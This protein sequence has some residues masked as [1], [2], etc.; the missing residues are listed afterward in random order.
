MTENLPAE[1]PT[2]APTASPPPRDDYAATVIALSLSGAYREG[3][4]LTL[5]NPPT[6]DQRQALAVRQRVLLTH[7]GRHDRKAVA[8]AVFEMIS[9]YPQMMKLKADEARPIVA[10]YVQELS[11][12]PTWAC[13]YACN[14]I[15]M[16]NAPGVSLQYVPSTMQVLQAALDYAKTWRDEATAIGQIL[17]GS[18]YEKRVSDADREKVAIRLA[19][20]GESMRGKISAERDAERAARRARNPLPTDEDLRRLY[21]PTVDKVPDHAE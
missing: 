18:K 13:E 5:M 17:S 6:K 21:A 7:L 8:K 15:R 4:T 20:L 14:T 3:K 16:G 11:G 12:V 1:R 2:S 9:C 19:Q 10:K